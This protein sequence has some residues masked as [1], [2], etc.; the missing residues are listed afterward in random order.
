MRWL[1]DNYPSNYKNGG[2]L[3]ALLL[4]KLREFSPPQHHRFSRLL[5]FILRLPSDITHFFDKPQTNP[6]KE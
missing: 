5:E 3:R 1:G 4:T 2:R 6:L